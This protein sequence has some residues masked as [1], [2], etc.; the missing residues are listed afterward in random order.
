MRGPS[1]DP[2]PDQY[3]PGV[4]VVNVELRRMIAKA[5]QAAGVV[6]EALDG[7]AQRASH[8]E[9]EEEEWGLSTPETCGHETKKQHAALW[10]TASSP[11]QPALRTGL[12]ALAWR[13]LH[14]SRRV[15][16]NLT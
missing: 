14:V 16:L 15:I 5:G 11:H 4:H 2:A 7:V 10:S 12:M 6:M 1:K 9:E 3:D 13:L 8:E